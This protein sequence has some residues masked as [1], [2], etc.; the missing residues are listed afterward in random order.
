MTLMST[1]AYSQHQSARGQFN[2]GVECVGVYEHVDRVG[3]EWA[4]FKSQGRCAEPVHVDYNLLL[5]PVT[6]KV[7]FDE[8][9]NFLRH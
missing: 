8:L 3:M 7:R 4:M 6:D 5:R 1:Y 9:H 2:F